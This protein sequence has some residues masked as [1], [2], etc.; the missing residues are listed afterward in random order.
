MY[1]KKYKYQ[2]STYCLSRKVINCVILCNPSVAASFFVCVRMCTFR[3]ATL[4][5]WNFTNCVCHTA[6]WIGQPVNVLVAAKLHWC[7]VRRTVGKP[8]CKSYSIH[9]SNR[10]SN[11]RKLSHIL[12]PHPRRMRQ[13]SILFCI[14]VTQRTCARNFFGSV[15]FVLV[16]ILFFFFILHSIYV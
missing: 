5:Y 7:T 12:W 15:C 3:I 10:R 8:P 13:T 14:W 9:G 11:N 6:L 1:K 4:Y 16:I 2:K